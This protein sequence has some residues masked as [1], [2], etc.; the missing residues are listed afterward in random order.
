MFG[1]SIETILTIASIVIL[2][3]SQIIL[4]LQGRTT[5]ANKIG[6]KKQKL[7]IKL[8]AQRERDLRNA[9]KANEEIK[10]LKSEE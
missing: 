7:L 5:E 10:K 2:T 9:E 3:I 8:E 1:L 4:F 6:V